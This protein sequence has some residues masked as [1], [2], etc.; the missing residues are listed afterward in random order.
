MSIA[1]PKG[2]RLCGV[3]AGIKRDPD[4]LDLTLVVSDRAATAAGVYTQNLVFAAPVKL[5]RARTPGSRIRAVVINS[6][7]ANACT[8]ERGDRDAARMAELAAAACGASGEQA[9]VLSTGVIGE[10]LPMEKIAAGIGAAAERLGSDESSLVAAAS[11]MM[12]TDTRH[13]LAGRS[14][15]AAGQTVQI[16]GMAKGAA[17]IGPR[18]ATMLGLILSDAALE[19]AVAQR[20]LSAS[21]EDSFNC[22]SVDGHMST[23]DTVLLVANGAAGTPPLAGP[24][25]ARFQQALAEV[26][27][28]LARAIPADG[29]GATHLVTVDVRGCATRAAAHRIAKTVAESPLVK[30]AL[31]GADPNWGRIVSAAGY[32]GVPFDPSGVTLHVNGTKLY[33]DGA[34]V[35]FEAD[36]VSKS[37]RDR[38]ETSIVL[39]FREGDAAVRFWSTDLTAEYVKL[40]ADYHT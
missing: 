13:K 16:T 21:V 34:P 29:E 2:F 22:I 7:N 11:G 15:Q 19:P 25:L 9:L 37:I 39:D 20:A 3:R 32:A 6:G 1:V 36:E 12:T 24:D 10:F 8:G 23:N 18:M 14:V 4:R 31:A 30:T 40:N 35:A 26:C 28:E 38:Y 17:M 33:H 27:G 5:D